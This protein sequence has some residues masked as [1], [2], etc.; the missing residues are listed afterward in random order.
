MD[1]E[2]CINKK[3]AK[4]SEP[5]EDLV[6]SLVKASGSKSQAEERLEMDEVTAG[7]KVSLLYDSLRE[8]LEALAVRKGFKIYNHECYTPFLKEI[9]DESEKGDEFDEVRKIRNAINYYGKEVSTE[10]AKDTLK[11]IEALRNFCLGLLGKNGANEIK[12]NSALSEPSLKDDW[13]N[14]YDDRWNKR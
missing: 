11:R 10:E 3:I 4:E 12:E 13:N 7:P 6:N 8:L 2:N 5:D 9:M 14:K 1:W